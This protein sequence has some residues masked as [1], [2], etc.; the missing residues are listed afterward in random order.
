MIYQFIL[1]LIINLQ[2]IPQISMNDTMVNHGFQTSGRVSASGVRVAKYPTR[3]NPKL[4]LYF[5]LLKI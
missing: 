3:H 1:Y 4:L 2:L 5:F